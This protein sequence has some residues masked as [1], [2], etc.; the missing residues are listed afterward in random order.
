MKRLKTL[1]K[2]FLWW[3]VAQ[4]VVGISWGVVFAVWLWGSCG[5]SHQ[6]TVERIAGWSGSL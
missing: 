6:C 4:I 5:W 2:W 1:G 3:Q